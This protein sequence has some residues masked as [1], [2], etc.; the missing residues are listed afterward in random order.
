MKKQLLPSGFEILNASAGSG[1]TYQLTK[2]Y[3]KLILTNTTVQ[4][5]RQILAL[6]FTNKAVSEMKNRILD[7]LHDFGNPNSDKTNNPLFHELAVELGFSNKELER[8]SSLALKLLLHN[9][10]FFE[11]STI[12]KFT[13]RVIKTFAKDL[14]ISQNFEVEL[15]YEILLAE[16]IGRLLQNLDKDERLK[17]VLID[18]S[19]EKVDAD[20]SWNIVYDLTT[21]GKLIFNENHHDHLHYLKN[22]SIKDFGLLKGFILKRLQTLFS[23]ASNLAQK[24]LDTMYN[25]NFEDTDFSRQTLPN[26]F[27][28]IIA[29]ERSRKLYE[30]K[31]ESG[32][33]SGSLLL[34]R[35]E[36]D[37]TQLF[38]QLL[39]IY[40]EIKNSIYEYLFFKNAYANVLPLTVLNE[41]S[42]EVSHIQKEKENLHISEFNK[43]IS[44]E[45]SNQPAPYIYE[46]LGERY[47]H[48][49][50]D[51]FQDT[52]K[53]QWKNLIP[54]IGNA[55]E[56]EN[57][58][59]EKGTLLL[60]G[61]VKQSIYRWRGGDPKQFLDISDKSL[62]PFTVQPR[63]SA[64]NTNWRSFETIINFNNDFFAHT[65]KYLK[66]PNYQNLYLEQ[67]QQRTNGKKGGYVEITFA[68]GNVEEVNLFYCEK[69]LETIDDILD[70]GFSLKDICILVRK[71]KEGILLANYLVEHAVPIISS[72]AL[73]L[74][75]NPEVQFLVSLLRFLDHPTENNYQFDVLEY[76]F[77]E[78]EYKHDLI[79]QQLGN[80]SGFLKT[81][82]RYDSHQEATHPLL[83]VLERAIFTFFPGD[84]CGAHVLHF[85]DVALER[86]VKSGVGIYE[87]LSYWDI[88]KEVLAISA[89]LNQDAIQVMTIH[90]SK[91]LEF[92]FVIFPFAEGALKSRMQEKKIWV[93]LKEQFGLDFNRLLANASPELKYHSK[94]SDEI[95]TKENDLS[96]LDDINVLYVAMTRAIHGLFIVTQESYGESFGKLFKSYLLE[97]G[98]WTA[99]TSCFIFGDFSENLGE[100]SKDTPIDPIPYICTQPNTTTKLAINSNSYWQEENHK[101]LEWGKVVHSLL[102]EISSLADLE[103]TLHNATN[104]GDI[105]VEAAETVGNIIHSIVDHP[106][107]SIYY[108]EQSNVKNEAE[109]MNSK[110]DLF[111]P[112]RLV[113][114]DNEVVIIDYKTGDNRPEHN[115][116]LKTYASILEELGFVVTHQILVYIGDEIE[117]VFI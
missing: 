58:H 56:T 100:K 13:H 38:I 81:E 91:G 87:F 44:K 80:L 116:Q 36:K 4:K 93:P 18:F 34:K 104:R 117:P 45:I 12:D 33:I 2:S 86:C 95:Y 82:Y 101:S 37:G 59:G 50:I 85:L 109:I 97:K 75:N 69:V 54:L 96:E 103:R 14:R 42:K 46:R 47:R 88:K 108:S 60:V 61:D 10:N 29:G 5:F 6:T 78:Q 35:V 43:L 49:F 79:V 55:L 23:K 48:Y 77:K 89:P 107:L 62:R 71:N 70:K 113:F 19:L 110:G 32:L 114:H 21:I 73:L 105:S 16:A 31:L 53:M 74:V 26:H 76:L 40:L 94:T 84:K 11:V 92:P 1:K 99:D 25:H 115:Q 15:D 41:I 68:P 64:L 111:R 22:K 3:L 51:E 65:A 67:S 112:D 8:K 7:S 17:K 9:Y 98:V 28:K 30:N 106:K 57:L 24:A 39:D 27:K 72:E 83:D 20:K 90:K 63:I 102:S 52:S 66:D